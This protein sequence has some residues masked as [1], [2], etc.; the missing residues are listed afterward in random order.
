MQEE[1]RNLG[2]NFKKMKE[3]ERKL[4]KMEGGYCEEGC[5]VLY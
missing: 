2:S 5:G 4:A 3:T 1:Y